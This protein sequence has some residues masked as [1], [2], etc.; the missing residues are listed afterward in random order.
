V[1]Q[2]DHRSDAE[3]IART[4]T[5]PESFGA[6]Y[7]RHVPGVLAFFR[8]RTSDTQIA[9][10]LTSEAFARAL[11]HAET[12]RPGDQPAAAWLYGIARNLLTDSYRRGQVEDDARRRLGFDRMVVT[13]L[14]YDRAD[15]IAD[16]AAELA[17]ADLDGALTLNQAH[18]VEARVLRDESYEQIASD[19]R[20]SRQVARQHVSRGLRSLKRRWEK[21]A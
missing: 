1:D 15:A 5:D 10:D 2:P 19:L 17:A 13:D 9:L 11:E 20:C 6:F 21:P 7:R 8:R 4:S 3:L 14:G 12:F 16:A 18:A